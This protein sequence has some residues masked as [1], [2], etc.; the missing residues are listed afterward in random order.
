MIIQ[1]RILSF[2]FLVIGTTGFFIGEIPL[3]V[4]QIALSATTWTL[5]DQLKTIEFLSSEVTRLQNIT[6][7]YLLCRDSENA[8]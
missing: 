5:T 2:I 6:P 7:D 8:R 3:G 1:G 4:S